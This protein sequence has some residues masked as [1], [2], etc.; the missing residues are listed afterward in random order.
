MRR[1]GNREKA[2]HDMSTPTTGISDRILAEYRTMAGLTLTAA[3]AARLFG[4]DSDECG[5]GRRWWPRAG[6]DAET[7]AGTCVKG[8][9]A[10]MGNLKPSQRS[11][12]T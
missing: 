7:M 8:E 10:C 1:G 11:R 12:A 2:E 3:Q 6:C 9:S 4:L 5:L